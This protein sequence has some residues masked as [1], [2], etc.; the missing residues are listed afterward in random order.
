M[1]FYLDEDLSPRVAELLRGKGL[2][3]VSA[4]EK[5]MIGASVEE[6]LTAAV[7]EGCALVTRTRNGFIRQ[8]KDRIFTA[9]RRH[10]TFG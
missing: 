3:A 4:H 7:N 5:G 6:Q 1:R 8:A 9:C 10:Y 2:N